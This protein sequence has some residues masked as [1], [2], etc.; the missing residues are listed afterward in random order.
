ML[1]LKYARLRAVPHFSSGIVGD[2]LS[3]RRVSPILAW[4]DFHARSRFTRSTIPEEK[5]GT[6]RSLKVRV[7]N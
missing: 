5:C 7:M 4:G 6:A 1:H 2:T 3:F